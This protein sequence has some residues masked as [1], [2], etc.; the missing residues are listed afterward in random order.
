MRLFIGIPLTPSAIRE[1]SAI[2]APLRSS[3]NTLRW[4]A[5][6]SWHVTLQFLGSTTPE[7]YLCLVSHLSELNCQPVPIQLDSL[8]IFDRAGV[9]YAG[10]AI[11]PPLLAL[12]KR[13][14]QATSYCGFTPEDRP[15]HPHIKLARGKGNQGRQELRKLTVPTLT[16]QPRSRSLADKFVLYESLLSPTGS[17]YEIRER[18]SLRQ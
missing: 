16:H 17:R 11:T 10:I 18:F 7:Q 6:E 4:S 14:T 5:P 1:L 13:V 3:S 12:Q 9:F 2:V 15:Y 8:D